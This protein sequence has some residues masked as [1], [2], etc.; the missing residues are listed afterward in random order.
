[1]SKEEHVDDH[2]NYTPDFTG[3]DFIHDKDIQKVR[4]EI[5]AYKQLVENSI[6]VILRE[7]NLQQ[8]SHENLNAFSIFSS[9]QATLIKSFRPINPSLKLVVTLAQY[10]SSFPIGKSANAGTYEYVFGCLSLRKK[11][12]KTFICKETMK[13]KIAELFLKTETDFT[14]HKK[15]SRK[16]FVLTQNEQTLADLIRL[17]NLEELTAFP[18]MEIEIHENACLLRNSRRSVTPEEA[19][20]F[21]KL[22]K[23]LIRILN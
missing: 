1:M 22:T 21:S 6:S 2:I 7:L 20:E 4:N 15:F 23:T 12:P 18:D 3:D 14:E 9:L 13:E 11:F 16:F 8:S 5:K 10:S 17:K 19:I